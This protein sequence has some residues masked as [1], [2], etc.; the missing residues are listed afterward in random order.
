[1][2][3]SKAYCAH[4]S[5]RDLG[6][7]V[8]EQMIRSGGQSDTKPPMLSSQASLMLP[9]SDGSQWLWTRIRVP[10]VT[11]S[12]RGVIKDLPCRVKFSVEKYLPN[13]RPVSGGNSVF[14]YKDESDMQKPACPI[15]NSTAPDSKPL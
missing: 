10:S 1:M 15:L 3:A 13:Y 11:G 4:L 14:K 7:E 8:Q 6:P 12:S 9:F 2:R 5:I